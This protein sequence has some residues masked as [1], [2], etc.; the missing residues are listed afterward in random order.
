MSATEST[1]LKIT[2]GPFSFTGA[3][4]TRE[5]ARRPSRPSSACCRSTRRSSTCAGA[6]SRPG[7]RSATSTSASTSKPENAT[8]YPAPGQVLWYPGGISETELLFPYGG[9]LFA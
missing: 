6:A 8:S 9:T 1:L 2:A 7:S 5:G 3:L 4:E